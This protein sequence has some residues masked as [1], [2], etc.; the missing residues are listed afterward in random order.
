M[1]RAPVIAD[2][3]ALIDLCE[4]EGCHEQMIGLLRQ[5]R[6]ATTAVSVFELWRGCETATERT[7]TRRALRGL[8]VY[9]FNEPA[10]MRAGELAQILDR[11]GAGIGERDTMIA[12]VCLAVGLPLLTANVKHFKRVP[13]LRVIPARAAS[14]R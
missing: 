4:Q 2:T 12:G 10:A 13:G 6:L 3:D 5:G 8:R 14:G 7:E 11:A 9:A 1:D